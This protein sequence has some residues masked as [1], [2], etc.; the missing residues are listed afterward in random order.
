MK[1]YVYVMILLLACLSCRYR[2]KKESELRKA[3]GSELTLSMID[4]VEYQDSMVM[5]Q[6]IKDKY[7][8]LLVVYLRDGCAPCY[9]EFLEWHG[10]IEKFKKHNNFSVLFIINGFTYQEFLQDIPGKMN[11]KSDYY[12]FMDP[13]FSFL[14]NNNKLP[15]WIVY[16]SLLID[17]DSKI[18]MVGA[19][20]LNENM[21]KMFVNLLEYNCD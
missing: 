7:D 21:G 19:P 17:C 18:R 6:E 2:S 5:F 14:D 10:R 12:I 8:F 20:F 16:K 3:I 15:R 1:I 4:Q 9:D 13:D 11:F